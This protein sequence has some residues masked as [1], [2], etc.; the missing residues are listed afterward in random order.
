MTTI[1]HVARQYKVSGHRFESAGDTEF[2]IQ[3]MTGRKVSE[4]AYPSVVVGWSAL[5]KQ[6]PPA[7]LLLHPDR[8]DVLLWWQPLTG[9]CAS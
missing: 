2:T 3:I 1:P 7:I 8:A 6:Q 5:M 4:S 9:N